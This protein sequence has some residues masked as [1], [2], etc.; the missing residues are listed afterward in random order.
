MVKKIF[1]VNKFYGKIRYRIFLLIFI[2]FGVDV[3]DPSK[4]A[5][6]GT[7]KKKQKMKFT[8]FSSQCC[9]KSKKQLKEEE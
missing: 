1:L 9:K 5:E 4:D 2:R 6:E 7:E 3:S 8:F